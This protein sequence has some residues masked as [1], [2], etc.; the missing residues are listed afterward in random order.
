MNAIIEIRWQQAL[1][2]S[3]D[4]SEIPFGEQRVTYTG[5]VPQKDCSVQQDGTLPKRTG[6]CAPIN[7]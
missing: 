7:D 6:N 4:G 5:N 2:N 3:P 1:N